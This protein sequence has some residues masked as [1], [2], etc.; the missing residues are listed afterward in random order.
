MSASKQFSIGHLLHIVWIL[1]IRIHHVQTHGN[2]F[3]DRMPKVSHPATTHFLV[4]STSDHD[5]NDEL[6]ADDSVHREPSS[7]TSSNT[8]CA[9]HSIDAS[10][11]SYSSF[12]LSN[13]TRSSTPSPTANSASNSASQQAYSVDIL[14][15]SEYPVLSYINHTAKYQQVF[16]PSWIPSSDKMKKQ[17]IMAQVQNCT[18][19]PGKCEPCNATS[20]LVFTA[21]NPETGSCRRLEA[22]SGRIPYTLLPHSPLQWNSNGSVNPL[23]E[24]TYYQNPS[25]FYWDNKYY[26]F[27]NHLTQQ[28]R[29]TDDNELDG[30]FKNINI[31][32]LWTSNN[33]TNLTGWMQSNKTFAKDEPLTGPASLLP[34]NLSLSPTARHYLFFGG[35]G[36]ISVTNSCSITSWMNID[37]APWLEA[38]VDRFDNDG[39]ETGPSPVKLADGNYLM[40]YNGYTLTDIQNALDFNFS[41][42]N[43]GQLPPKIKHYAIGWLILDGNNPTKILQRSEKPIISAS[44][45]YETGEAPF[46]CMQ[47]NSVYAKAIV[48]IEAS[49]NASTTDT[50]RVYFSAADTSIG[51][52]VISVAYMPTNQAAKDWLTVAIIVSVGCAVFALTMFAVIWCKKNKDGEEM[53]DLATE[54][55]YIS[56]V[57][58][59]I[60]KEL[61]GTNHNGAPYVIGSL[62]RI[63]GATRIPSVCSHRSRRT[64]KK[65]T[66]KSK[67]KSRKHVQTADHPHVHTTECCDDDDP[68]KCKLHAFLPHHQQQLQLRQ[69]E[70]AL[71][72]HSLNSNVST[73]SLSST[74]LSS[75]S[76]A[77]ASSSCST[78]ESPSASS[79]C[80]HCHGRIHHN[81]QGNQ[82]EHSQS[83]TKSDTVHLS[84]IS[85]RINETLEKDSP[86]S[87]GRNNV[88]TVTGYNA[89]NTNFSFFTAPNAG[90]GEPLL[91]N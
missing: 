1:L 45:K 3:A 18:L 39:V 28:Q 31:L 33:P 64:Q 69:D 49:E 73:S 89:S 16:N 13:K 60:S 52:A 58:A 90:H 79:Y 36:H 15:E 88:V 6:L 8:Y 41:V 40:L 47:H 9:G 76:T 65:E 51:T 80:S 71:S 84:Q 83:N 7:S 17:G 82:H 32:E 27:V 2:F 30:N 67:T 59:H 63:S 87:T 14:S 57:S 54:P 29:T 46:T 43:N 24:S 25:I 42:F 66:R 12:D 81:E 20:G 26:M 55:E 5:D 91:K 86:T 48:R 68:E 77:T 44:Y 4:T 38:R 19:I 70:N 72:N 10:D 53:I 62:D 85:F 37:Y 35:Q 11:Q 56:I 34:M 23:Y 78:A 74:S 50:F 22:P 61:S 21:C 75:S